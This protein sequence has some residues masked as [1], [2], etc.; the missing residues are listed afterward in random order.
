[1]K[2]PIPEVNEMLLK[3]G[4]NPEMVLSEE[5]CQIQ[6]VAAPPRLVMRLPKVF[7]RG[8]LLGALLAHV[9]L[10]KLLGIEFDLGQLLERGRLRMRE[11]DDGA[12]H[13]EIVEGHRIE[14]KF[15]GQFLEVQVT[16]A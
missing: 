2:N 13:Q 5:G 10:A 4:R 3:M 14:A 7:D 1:M 9:A 11:N 16:E 15:S 6:M 8:Q 12:V